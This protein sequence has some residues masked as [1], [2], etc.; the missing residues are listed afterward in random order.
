MHPGEAASCTASAPP[1]R[2]RLAAQP[3]AQLAVQLAAQ[4]AA[5]LSVQLAVPWL[6][7]LRRG[8]EGVEE[9]LEMHDAEARR[10]LGQRP[11]E[12]ALVR[13]AV[14]PRSRKQHLIAAVQTPIGYNVLSDPR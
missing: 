5:E 6:F 10:P 3:A 11:A 13:A 7:D 4:P 14:R 9:V 2:S 12:E 1:S 8:A